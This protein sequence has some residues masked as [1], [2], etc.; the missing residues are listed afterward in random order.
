MAN[1]I[2][3]Y[4]D[5]RDWVASQQ[6]DLLIDEF[7]DTNPLQWKLINPLI[8]KINLFC[9]GDDA[10]SIYGFRGADFENIHKFKEMS[11]ILLF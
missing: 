8:N 1:Q 3:N 7:Q 11:K 9:V 6:S 5:I 2:T 4:S 10:Q